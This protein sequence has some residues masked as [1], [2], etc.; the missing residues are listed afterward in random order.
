MLKVGSRIEVWWN[1]KTAFMFQVFIFEV[2]APVVIQHQMR[3]SCLQ[4]TCALKGGLTIRAFQ[5]FSVI[6][7]LCFM[8]TRSEVRRRERKEEIHG[9]DEVPHKLR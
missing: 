8:E 3:Q 5:P 1:P 4:E 7:A 9:C 2:Y 6:K